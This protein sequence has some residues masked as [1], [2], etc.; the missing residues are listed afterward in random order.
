MKYEVIKTVQDL[1]NKYGNQIYTDSRKLKSFLND[2]YPG[3][4]A[5]DIRLLCDSVDQ[6]IP[7]D[8]LNSTGYE[9][10]DYLYNILVRKLYDNLGISQDLAEETV[11]NWIKILGKSHIKQVVNNSSMNSTVA[12]NASNYNKP[13]I[14]S[15]S[16]NAKSVSNANTNYTQSR[17]GTPINYVPMDSNTIFMNNTPNVSKTP[18]GTS[19]VRSRNKKIIAVVT[20]IVLLMISA[21]VG[22][23]VSYSK[24]VGKAKVKNEVGNEAKQNNESK[25]VEQNKNTAS[26]ETTEPDIVLVQNL[27]TNY[28]K[29]KMDAINKNNFLELEPYLLTN[30]SIYKQDKNDVDIAGADSGKQQTL[31]NYKIK[32]IRRVQENYEVTMDEKY[33]VFSS[34]N[35]TDIEYN[36]T[37]F[38]TSSNDKWVLSDRN[39]KIVSSKNNETNAANIKADTYYMEYCIN[40]YLYGMA[41]AINTMN[42]SIVEPYLVPGSQLYNDQKKLISDLNKQNIKERLLEYKI[43]NIEPIAD[44]Y[45]VKTYEKYL[46]DYNGD[47]KSK[48]FQSTYIVRNVNGT[49][50]VSD[51]LN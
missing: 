35:P 17:P 45:K 13:Y 6:K 1:T 51:M 8:I 29:A 25:Q 21:A 42:F 50:G 19:G 26:N 48:D 16:N 18:H 5:R 38:V 40:S 46:I 30:S 34:A 20:M 9:I 31:L 33:T 28:E 3:Q 12:N 41:E 27:I 44:G 24:S 37:Y 11:D 4:H 22:Y 36:S 49:W 39:S 2:F 7:V 32:D 47:E 15:S 14:N 10:E 23:A 43:T